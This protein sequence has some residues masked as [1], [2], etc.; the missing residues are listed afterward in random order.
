M[1]T[2]AINTTASRTGSVGQIKPTTDKDFTMKTNPLPDEPMKRILSPENPPPLSPSEVE[3]ERIYDEE[4]LASLSK[5]LDSLPQQQQHIL[6]KRTLEC[7]SQ[8][9]D[10]LWRR[11]NRVPHL[12]LRNLEAVN[13]K[14][15]YHSPADALSNVG[16]L[17]GQALPYTNTVMILT[18]LSF[19]PKEI[20]RQV[21]AHEAL[22]I[23]YNLLPPG[24]HRVECSEAIS[25]AVREYPSCQQEEEQWV[26]NMMARLGF[27]ENHLVF[28]ELAV[29]QAG[30]D[31]RPAY[32][33]L[34]REGAAI[35]LNEKA[36]IYAS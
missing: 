1:N 2:I 16:I 36:E 14:L 7:A 5:Q 9:I 13:I 28:W 23:I 27:N 21:A 18:L 4:L 20:I 25:T 15:G 6:L 26:R 24:S 35:K 32:Y 17:W 31:W 29:E 34:K 30:K 19:A 3:Q 33:A 12:E 8:A 11:L 22:H 10:D